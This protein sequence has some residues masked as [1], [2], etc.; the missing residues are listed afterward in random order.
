MYIG[1][2]EYCGDPVLANVLSIA[3]RILNIFQIVMPIIAIVFLVRNLIRLMA[4]P[5]EKKLHNVL[6]NWFV[7]LVLF[8]AL[9]IIVDAVMGLLSDDYS[10]SACWN[11]AKNDNLSQQSPYID[12]DG[13]NH[14]IKVTE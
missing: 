3:Q 12:E 14:R 11:L 10:L 8:F 6:R 2:V 13:E 5:E 7:A 1:L 4:T 9:P